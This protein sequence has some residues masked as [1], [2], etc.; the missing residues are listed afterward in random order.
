MP[1]L[2]SGSDQRCEPQSGQKLRAM[3][4]PESVLV[5]LKT[6]G[7]P[8]VTL[9]LDTSDWMLSELRCEWM[10]SGGRPENTYCEEWSFWHETQ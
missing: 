5:S 8:W 3:A 4:L 6:F 9:T 10:G 1:G 7:V 2:D